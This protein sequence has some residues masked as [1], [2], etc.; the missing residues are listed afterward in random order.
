MEFNG[1]KEVRLALLYTGR[2]EFGLRE[3]ARV[4]RAHPLRGRNSRQVLRERDEQVQHHAVHESNREGLS[5][6]RRHQLHDNDGPEVE[7]TRA[8][9]ALSR[10]GPSLLPTKLV[11]WA[12]YWAGTQFATEIP[13]AAGYSH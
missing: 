4:P 2:R 6:P 1:Y 9:L 7:I 11:L 10:A 12:G 3:R 5:K 8:G 13:G